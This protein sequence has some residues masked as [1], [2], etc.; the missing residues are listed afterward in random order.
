V[1]PSTLWR[2][3]LFKLSFKFLLPGKNSRRISMENVTFSRGKWR[4]ANL[5]KLIHNILS[6]PSKEISSWLQNVRVQ[7]TTASCNSENKGLLRMANLHLE[8]CN[9]KTWVRLSEEMVA[10]Q[11][12]EMILARIISIVLLKALFPL[13]EAGFYFASLP[14]CPI[15]RKIVMMM[16]DLQLFWSRN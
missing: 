5:L 1:L 3:P 11:C 7:E 15:P 13:I 4:I 14:W 10:G 12:I 2:S 16:T 9:G 6:Q 8:F